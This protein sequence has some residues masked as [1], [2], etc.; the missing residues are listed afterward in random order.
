MAETMENLGSD[1][2]FSK[3]DSNLWPSRTGSKS[4]RDARL[5]RVIV[6]GATGT[7]YYRVLQLA[8]SWDYMSG[9][10]SVAKVTLAELNFTKQLCNGLG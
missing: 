10:V 1:S 2:L 3:R 6:I 9:N 5:S 4:E 8:A 7:D